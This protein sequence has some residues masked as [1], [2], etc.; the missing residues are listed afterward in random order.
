MLPMRLINKSPL[1]EDP[2]TFRRWRDIAI[3]LEVTP[4]FVMDLKGP[5]AD[6]MELQLGKQVAEL[7]K[8]LL[9]LEK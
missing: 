5:Y 8:T 3:E 9:I 2:E 1:K 4:E 7:L 6:L